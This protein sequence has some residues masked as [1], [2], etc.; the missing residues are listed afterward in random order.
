MRLRAEKIL[1]IRLLQSLG[2]KRRGR[3]PWWWRRGVCGLRLVSLAF[4]PGVGV[5]DEEVG[6]AEWACRFGGGDQAVD[7]LCLSGE[8]VGGR[9]CPGGGQ[10]D[11]ARGVG[12]G[13]IEPGSPSV[14]WRVVV[15]DE[16][17]V[18][19]GLHA[20]VPWHTRRGRGQVRGVISPTPRVGRGREGDGDVV[21]QQVDDMGLSGVGGGHERG[22]VLV[23]VGHVGGALM[24]AGAIG[25]NGCGCVVEDLARCRCPSGVTAR[26]K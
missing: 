6:E 16:G 2:F 11:G 15:A 26:G 7:G 14:W 19:V 8:G 12:V 21:A 5:A 24:Q 1:R 10:G 4:F 9:S 3:W 23:R 20:F 25:V 13:A 22:D 18:G 17:W